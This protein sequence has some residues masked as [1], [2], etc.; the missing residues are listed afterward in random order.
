MLQGDLAKEPFVTYFN[1]GNGTFFNVDGETTFNNEWYNVGIQ[2]YLP[3]WRWWWTTEFMGR[4][5]TDVPESG[6]T[7][8]FTWDDAWFGG[9]CMRITGSTDGEYLQLFKMNYPVVAGDKLTIRY[10]LLSGSVSMEW[11][12]ATTSSIEGTTARIRGNSNLGEW[13]EVTVEISDE[14]IADLNIPGQTLALLG[15]HFTS[16]EDLDMLIGEISLTREDAPTPHP[17]PQAPVLRKDV[18]GTRKAATASEEDKVYTYEHGAAIWDYTYEG[19]TVKLV[20]TMGEAP[21]D[22]PW[23]S[24]RNSDVDTWYYKVYVQQ[25]DGDPVMCTAT[26][27]WAAYVVNAPVDPELGK[28]R[29]G[30]SAVS[31]DGKSESNITWSDYMELPEPATVDGIEVDK[32]VIKPGEEFTV[33]YVDPNY[34]AA[35]KWEIRAADVDDDSEPLMSSENSTSV[36]GTLDEIGLYDVTVISEDGTSSVHRGLVQIS[37]EEVG[38]MPEITSIAV[39]DGTETVEAE[40]GESVTYSYVGRDADGSVSRGL[41]LQSNAFGMDFQQFGFNDQ[42]PFT[43]A[44]WSWDRRV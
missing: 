21:A 43:V 35:Q 31:L 2:D 16:A 5:E 12:A 30:V 19:A 23:E 42:S 28:L 44:Y 36:S 3:T 38:A 41:S 37:G 39:N 22:K 9:S 34:P 29:V 40:T 25:E 24:V 33:R 20:W 27:S 7:A 13:Q 17:T 11:A 6:L 26:T 1:L 18:K 14:S 4:D 32:A 10:K 8:T 15:L